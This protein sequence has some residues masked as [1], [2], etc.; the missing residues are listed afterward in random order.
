MMLLWIATAADGCL[1]MTVFRRRSKLREA[2][3]EAFSG[4]AAPGR[5]STASR[6]A[7][8]V[9]QF[10]G[11]PLSLIAAFWCLLA[12]PNYAASRD[13]FLGRQKLD[14]GSLQRGYEVA[15]RARLRGN[16]AQLVVGNRCAGYL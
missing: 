9:P 1:A 7:Q 13:I 14:A 10:P 4:E 8:I 5:Y 2:I 11:A 12:F 3:R 6:G 15:E 16:L